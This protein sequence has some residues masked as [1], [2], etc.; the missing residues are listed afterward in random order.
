MKSF[1]NFKLLAGF[2][3]CGTL[4]GCQEYDLEKVE[5]VA[6]RH[7]YEKGF[8]D[9]YGEIDPN[10]SWDFSSYAK[11]QASTRAAAE[12]GYTTI[13]Y[14]D[15]R[16]P[17]AGSWYYVPQEIIDHLNTIWKE[18][19]VHEEFKLCTFQA[20]GR[21]STYEL[22]PI[23]QGA[24]AMAY[25]INLVEVKPDGT[26]VRD[27][28]LMR[29]G[30]NIQ[31]KDRSAEGQE[32]W[33]THL[34]YDERRN[35]GTRY[36]EFETGAKSGLEVRAKP[37]QFTI[38]KDNFF[39]F[40][41]C[42]FSAYDDAYLKW[43]GQWDDPDPAKRYKNVWNPYS[44]DFPPQLGALW[45]DNPSNVDPE[46]ECQVLGWEDVPYPNNYNGET[47]Y[48]DLDY[49]DW[50]FLLTGYSTEPILEEEP[51]ESVIRKQYQIEDLGSTYDYDFND[52]VVT[53]S[54]RREG[55]YVLNH[56]TGVA[57]LQLDIDRQWAQVNRLCG[58]RPIQIKVGNDWFG[59]VTNPTADRE[60][61]IRQL[62]RT[63]TDILGD[64]SLWDKHTPVNQTGVNVETG[65]LI[66]GWDPDQNNV[67]VRVW[68][69]NDATAAPTE[70]D[71]VWTNEFPRPGDYPYM[72][73]FDPDHEIMEEGDHIP[74]SWMFGGDMSTV[75]Q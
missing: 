55:K 48:C 17:D 57:T 37:V 65:K 44:I 69:V 16:Y 73:A 54:W 47:P 72:I 1:L 38:E 41:L 45:L 43:G 15:P 25:D 63:D 5:E 19:E 21:K 52:I 18:G 58:T 60:E 62:K 26:K 9:L 75:G 53:A 6:F 20:K 8:V 24:V 34:W 51:F 28:K 31:R 40:Y 30:D 10:Q 33:Q 23:Y 56:E 59:Q 66:T 50:M 13:A 32:Y 74:E 64:G 70:T 2:L 3:A 7:G 29:R 39:Y 12:D 61:I 4:V 22:T 49:N 27:I 35:W 67:L 68:T 36:V 14:V 71:K 46:Y 11:Q 42:N